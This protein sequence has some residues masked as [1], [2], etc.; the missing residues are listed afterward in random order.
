MSRLLALSGVVSQVRHRPVKRYNAYGEV[1]Y[2]VF[3]KIRDIP[4]HIEKDLRFIV[5]EGLKSLE[6]ESITAVGLR[7]DAFEVIVLRRSDGTWLRKDLPWRLLWRI[8]SIQN[9][10]GTLFLVVLGG[11]SS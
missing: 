1:V 3:F 8:A 10:V 11:I 4:A 2:V 6:G 9:L 5:D 7:R